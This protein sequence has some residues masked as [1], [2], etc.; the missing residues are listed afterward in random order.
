MATAVINRSILGFSPKVC[1]LAAGILPGLALFIL[2]WAFPTFPGDEDAILKFQSLRTGWLDD[3]AVVFAN[4]GKVEVFLPATGVL[5]AVL[6][7]VRRFGDVAMVLA[8]LILIGVGN[9][10]KE[11]IVRPRP[12]YHIGG[13]DPSS[14][15]FPS[16]HA[17]LAIILG[18][19]LVY[20]IERSVRPLALRRGIQ[21][22]LILVAAAMGASRV[23]LGVH[24]P[25]DVIGAYVFGAMA[26]VGLVWLRNALPSSR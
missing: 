15:S 2:A 22:A 19:V 1:L 25:S 3:V 24:W 18:G 5:V 9:G 16:G 7:Y 6:L 11:L 4:L 14:F 10:L 23:Y 20:L 26:L 8:G 17:V 13:P 21:I 12:E